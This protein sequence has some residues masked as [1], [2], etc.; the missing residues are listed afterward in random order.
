[1]TTAHQG[2]PLRAALALLAVALI[3]LTFAAIAT[4]ADASPAKKATEHLVVRGEDT[5]KDTPCPTGVCPLELTDGAF[6]GTIG[7]GAYSGSLELHVADAFPNGESGVCAPIN[8]TITLGAGTPD[9]LV[10]SLWGQSCQDGAGDPKTSSF[11]G[12]AHFRVKYGTGTYANATGRGLM[13][14]FEGADDREH[15]TLIG[16]I[17]K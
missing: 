5:V 11:T 1:M 7:K 3:G 16:R 2:R 15:M 8:G 9:R 4:V 12:L 17:T 14:S 6:R 10:L 13:S